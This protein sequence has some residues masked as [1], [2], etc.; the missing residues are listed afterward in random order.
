MFNQIFQ[1]GL[2]FVTVFLHTF[3]RKKVCPPERQLKIII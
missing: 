1:E 2:F 3:F